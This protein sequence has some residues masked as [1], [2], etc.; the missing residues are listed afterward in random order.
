MRYHFI[1]IG[2]AVMHQ[3]ALHLLDSG[4]HITGSDDAIFDP[5]RLNLQNHGILPE[6]YGWYPEKITT[7]IDAVILGMHAK[8]DNPELVRAQSLGIKVYSFPEFVYE[9]AKDKT[10]IVVA[11]SNGKTTTT[12]MIMHQLRCAGY[13]FDYL[14]GSKIEGFD[15]MVKVTPSAK[16]IVIEGDEY[17]TSP[18]DLRSKFLHYKPHYAIITSIDWDHINVFPTY[19][20]YLETFK[21]F[22][23]DVQD[24]IYYYGQDSAL[25]TL[26]EQSAT[27]AKK[28][29]YLP[30]SYQS[31]HNIPFV[32]FEEAKY[33]SSVFGKHNFSNWS[34]ALQ[35]CKVLGISEKDFYKNMI[36][37]SGAARRMEKVYEHIAK[38]IVVFRDFAHAP[39]KLRATVNAARENYPSHTIIAVFELHTFSSMQENFIPQY[40]NAM[41]KCD[42]AILFMDEK[43]FAQK[44]KQIIDKQWLVSHFGDPQPFVC[45][46]KD[47]L[48][49]IMYPYIA[50]S[51]VFLI[52]SSGHLGGWNY[53]DLEAKIASI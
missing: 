18:L 48:E 49:A 10:R 51:S 14:V 47:E 33:Q 15:Y 23:G 27:S 43:S 39:A 11:G 38:N 8:A 16:I 29:S 52:M 44:G 3:L 6:K 41:E 13:D 12:S 45:S 50:P 22:I 1:A 28:E 4:H 34:A 25:V 9:N 40:H 53:K 5:A 30:L 46:Q 19:D 24:T 21:K 20:S 17:L 42:V 7:D 36:T 35:I 31:E 26:I 37:F 2:G 32:V